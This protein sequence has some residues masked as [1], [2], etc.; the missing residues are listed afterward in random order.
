MT[1][2]Y[3]GLGLG[4]IS[5]G[6]TIIVAI[7]VYQL[8][9]KENKSSKDIL[10]KINEITENQAKIIESFDKRRIKHVDWF[11]HH[12]GGVLESLKENSR[13]LI[14]RIQKYQ[15]TKS[16]ED[17]PKIIAGIN[18]CRMSLNQLREH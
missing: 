13:E 5:I 7:L 9:K 3:I 2:T 18:R 17:L 1:L 12:V 6:V 15:I 14:S 4:I 10:N 11:V 8:Q 16:E